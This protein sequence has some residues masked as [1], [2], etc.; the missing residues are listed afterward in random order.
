VH[1]KYR[2]ETLDT[3]IRMLA[4]ELDDALDEKLG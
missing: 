1:E 3:R 4:D 2:Q